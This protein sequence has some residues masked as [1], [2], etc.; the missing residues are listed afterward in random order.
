MR[1]AAAILALMLLAGCAQHQKVE[2][3]AK[4]AESVAGQ[5][6]IVPA[7]STPVTYLKSQFFVAW[8]INTATGALEACTYDPG[9]WVTVTSTI[10][11]DKLSCT[12]ANN[13]P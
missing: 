11:P 1:T 2:P 13:P 8:R 4:P 6:A 10:A 3:S 9:G 5:W 12:A 7:S